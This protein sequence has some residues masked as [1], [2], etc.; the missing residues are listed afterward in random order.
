MTLQ[1]KK[2]TSERTLEGGGHHTQEYHLVNSAI[3]VGRSPLFQGPP[4]EV[5]A[6]ATFSGK[7]FLN[8]R[9]GRG[10]AD[11]RRAAITRCRRP[12]GVLRQDRQG[13][14]HAFVGGAAQPHHRHAQH[15][16]QASS[17]EMGPN[18]RSEEHTSE[19][20]SLTNLV[21]RLLLEKKK[22]TARDREQRLC[23]AKLQPQLLE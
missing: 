22:N 16:V 5:A 17:L 23:A 12:Q 10:E 9:L 13:Q 20:Q 15:P 11:V 18:V 14:C 1:L 2:S 7:S 4:P 6:V 8:P 21:C 3:E 19:L